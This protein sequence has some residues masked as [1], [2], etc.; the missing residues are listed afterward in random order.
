MKQCI[1]CGRQLPDGANF[2]PGCGTQ[3][4]AAP[5]IDQWGRPNHA[6]HDPWATTPVPE[7][8]KK[9]GFKARY[10]VIP[11]LLAVVCA[12]GVFAY[13][14]LKHPSQERWYDEDGNLSSIDYAY[15]V[16]KAPSEIRYYDDDGELS[17]IEFYDGRG[18]PKRTVGYQDDEE[19]WKETYKTTSEAKKVD[20]DDVEDMD[21]VT[22]VEAFEC[23]FESDDEEKSSEGVVIVVGYNRLGE[24]AGQ[25]VFVK[26][27]GEYVLRESRE[28]EMDSHGHHSK[29]T[30]TTPDGDVIREWE[31]DNEYSFGR[32]VK[33]E[34]SGVS[35]GNVYADE[36]GVEV[37]WNE[38][39]FEWENV[40]EF[41]Y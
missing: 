2:C 1:R 20:T 36:D 27:D 4:I 3:Q 28:Y 29:C 32:L 33:S 18:F 39:P 14:V 23:F 19:S 25:Q 38:E 24:I 7:T 30:V 13:R 17:T 8:P 34:V 11:I 26:I 10:V 22:K 15:L 31:I 40:N 41:E 21:G 9:K 35:Y 12:A 16:L 37:E 5:P 6:A